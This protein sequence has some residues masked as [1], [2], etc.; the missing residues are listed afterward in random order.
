MIQCMEVVKLL[1][2][3]PMLNEMIWN[4]ED[5]LM[6]QFGMDFASKSFVVRISS[7]GGSCCCWSFND[8]YLTYAHY[9]SKIS[10]IIM[11]IIVIITKLL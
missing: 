7:K 11:Y 9:N 8:N 5:A 1:K 2:D 3:T 4:L 10:V 6:K